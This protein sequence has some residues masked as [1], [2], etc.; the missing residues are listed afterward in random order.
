MVF[1]LGLV[2]EPQ[3][4]LKHISLKVISFVLE[5]KISNK[6]FFIFIY[7]IRF[8]QNILVSAGSAVSSGGETTLPFPLKCVGSVL[9][10]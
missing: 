3:R 9:H 4:R 8:L 10:R 7:S 6:A 2:V 1:E 5:N